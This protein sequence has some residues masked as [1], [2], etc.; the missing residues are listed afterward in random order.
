VVFLFA[1]PTIAVCVAVAL[2]LSRLR[3]LEEACTDLAVAV[4]RT[5]ELRVPLS[6]VRRELVRS[7]PLVDRIWSHW[8]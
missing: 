5:N 1:V 7:Q 3:A 2:V 8:Q 4:R 6:Q